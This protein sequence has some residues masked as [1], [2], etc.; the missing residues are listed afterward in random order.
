MRG[1]C[2]EVVAPVAV[3]WATPLVRATRRAKGGQKFTHGG[4]NG[5][6][7]RKPLGLPRVELMRTPVPVLELDSEVKRL[8]TAEKNVTHHVSEPK[9]H[10]NPNEKQSEDS[11]GFGVRRDVYLYLVSYVNGLWGHTPRR[12]P[13]EGRRAVQEASVLCRTVE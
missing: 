12:S 11:G 6:R 10:I 5:I 9:Q 4:M 7:Q 8:P 13:S 1:E 2:P 3:R